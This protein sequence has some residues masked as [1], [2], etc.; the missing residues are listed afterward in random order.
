M[1]LL[2]IILNIVLIGFVGFLIY[3]IKQLYK[4]S[5]SKNIPVSELM[6]ELEKDPATI[7]HAYFYE[8]SGAWSTSN[9]IDWANSKN[10]VLYDI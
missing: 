1:G 10:I 6:S 9:G 7:S 4:V 2:L 8:Q 3:T 5:E